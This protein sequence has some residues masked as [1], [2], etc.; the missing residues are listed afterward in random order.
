MMKRSARGG[1]LKLEL[2]FDDDDPFLAG[3]YRVY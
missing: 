3:C 1:I 2:A